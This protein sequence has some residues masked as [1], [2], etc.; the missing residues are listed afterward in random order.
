LEKS[1]SS[2]AHGPR[3]NPYTPER[4]Q[5]LRAAAENVLALVRECDT[6]EAPS[7][8]ASALL[9]G[10]PV[11]VSWVLARVSL[12]SAVVEAEKV[13]ADMGYGPS[14]PFDAPQGIPC[15]DGLFREIFQ[16]RELLFALRGGPDGFAQHPPDLVTPSAPSALPSWEQ[17]KRPNQPAKGFVL[18]QTHRRILALVRK[19]ARKGA[20][21]ARDLDLD[22]DYVRR[23]LSQLVRA[24]YLEN[25]DRGYK[26]LRTR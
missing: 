24:G 25:N 15:P 1:P 19:R 21:I 6:R 8:A 26:A 23:L 16:L 5:A 3:P 13:L 14:P 17:V 22:F 11:P 18:N 20:I 10:V 4:V 9:E 7:A 2:A 12:T